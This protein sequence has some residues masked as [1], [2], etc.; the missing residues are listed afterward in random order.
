MDVC[1]YRFFRETGSCVSMCFMHRLIRIVEISMNTNGNCSPI[2]IYH[3]HIFISIIYYYACNIF[4]WFK[5]LDISYHLSL[6]DRRLKTRWLHQMVTFSALMA[7]CVRN[8]PV[9]G[10]FP[11]QMPMTRSFDVFFDLCLNKRLSKQSWGWWFETQSGSLW[12]R[13]NEETMQRI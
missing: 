9:P 1:Q 10:E 13:C 2:V 12:R 7:L 4:I 5:R 11:V 6:D 3:F 8:S